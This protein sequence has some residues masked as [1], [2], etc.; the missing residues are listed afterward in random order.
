MGLYVGLSVF[1]FNKSAAK[2][3]NVKGARLK[4]IDDRESF[5]EIITLCVYN[6]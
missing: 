4:L 5:I 6:G 3:K 1:K 2:V